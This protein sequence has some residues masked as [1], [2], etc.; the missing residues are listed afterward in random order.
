MLPMLDSKDSSDKAFEMVSIKSTY[1]LH[2]C[3]PPALR[4]YVNAGDNGSNGDN[5]VASGRKLRNNNGSSGCNLALTS[6]HTASFAGLQGS[7][8]L[9]PTMEIFP[10]CQAFQLTGA[11]HNDSDGEEATRHVADGGASN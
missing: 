3:I 8:C 9:H 2:H 6:T 7:R 4:I 11:L 5:A 1:F 10:S